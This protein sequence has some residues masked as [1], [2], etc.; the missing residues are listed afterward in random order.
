MLYKAEEFMTLLDC[1]TDPDNITGR[2]FISFRQGHLHHQRIL[3]TSRLGKCVI[4]ISCLNIA[5]SGFSTLRHYVSTLPEAT[6][7][8]RSRVS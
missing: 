8:F 3:S 7:S 1:D 5:A 6:T 4:V 2:H